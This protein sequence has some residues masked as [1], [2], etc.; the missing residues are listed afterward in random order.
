M[1]PCDSINLLERV[2]AGSAKTSTNAD[3]KGCCQRGS[4]RVTAVDCRNAWVMDLSRQDGAPG[5]V[6]RTRERGA[7]HVEQR[8]NN[9]GL[10]L[11]FPFNHTAGR[12]F[13]RL[14]ADWSLGEE[15]HGRSSGGGLP[16][17]SANKQ[18]QERKSVRQMPGDRDR[19][20]TTTR[21]CSTL[22]RPWAAVPGLLHQAHDRRVLCLT[23][24]PCLI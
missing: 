4:R 21:R 13:P 16:F 7:T 9:S 11:A 19:D 22:D 17:A 20:L 15:L 5:E 2:G 23:S 12:R 8:R 1:I 10:V 14:R 6:T 18:R 3:G 24:G